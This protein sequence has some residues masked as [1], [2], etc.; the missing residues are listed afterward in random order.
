[1][2]NG[3]AGNSG[4]GNGGVGNGGVANGGAGAGGAGRPVFDAGS[5]PNRNKVPGG[6][7]CE[8]VATVQC[9]GEAACCDAPG[10]SFDQC[11]AVMK[12]G[13]IKQLYLDAVTANR[14]SGYDMNRAEAAFSQ[15]ETM[16]RNCD[17]TVAFWG[18]SATGL[19]GVAQ[20]TIAPGQACNPSVIDLLAKKDV[21]AAYLASC[22]D[23][24]NM[25]CLPQG[26]TNWTCVSR[27]GPG[28][29]CITDVNCVDGVFCDNPKLLLTGASCKPRKADGSPCA[30]ANECASLSCKGGRCSVP[31]PQSAYCLSN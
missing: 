13:C 6:Q 5:D 30:A 20:G 14:V 23:P 18:A 15:F 21:D 25:A 28:A 31:G 11:K 22:I 24:A 3:G 2:G 7:V 16:A 4:A 26:T 19:R 8:R 29:P 1:V 27:G 17:P 12:D 10:R 9:A